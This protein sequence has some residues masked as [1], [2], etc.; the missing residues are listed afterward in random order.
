LSQRVTGGT[1]CL[2]ARRQPFRGGTS[3]MNREIHVR[4]CERLGVKFPGPTRRRA[5]DRSPYADYI[6]R[7]K[8]ANP[9][10]SKIRNRVE[11]DVLVFVHWSGI[12]RRHYVQG[13][14]YVP[15]IALRIV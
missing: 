3:R 11:V 15:V 9:P 1:H 12:S 13:S 6:R 7:R 4:L 8:F 14:D 10:T 5:G 2:A